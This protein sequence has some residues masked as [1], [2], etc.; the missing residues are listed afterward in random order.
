M[1]CRRMSGLI[2]AVAGVVFW[3]Q[4]HA[5]D[6]D[7]DLSLDTVPQLDPVEIATGWYVR[8]DIGYGAD[9]GIGGYAYRTFDGGRY[10]THGGSANLSGRVNVG[11]GLGYAFTD[12]LRADVTVSRIA[13]AFEGRG[14]CDSSFPGDCVRQ[15]TADLTGYS[16]LANGYVDLGTIMG[17]TPYVGAGAGYTH[18]TW[19]GV[20]SRN[21][22]GDTG[23][24]GSSA[25]SHA[26]SSGWRFTYAL[27]AGVAYDLRKDLKLDIGYRYLHVDGGRMYG[28]DATNSSAGAWDVQGRYDDLE[29]HEIRVGLRFF[30]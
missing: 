27:M 11:L 17:F 12:M 7:F 26:G 4:A 13:A 29:A 23:C 21:L 14:D 1:R 30:F 10:A 2:A 9:M 5:A 15:V 8:G 28:W 22:C 24:A 6:E 20:K 16:A 25:E 3:S 18:A 19:D